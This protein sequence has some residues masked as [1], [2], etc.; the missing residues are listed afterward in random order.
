MRFSAIV[1]LSAL[2]LAFPASMVSAG[3]LPAGHP[4]IDALKDKLVATHAGV[5]T[6]AISATSYTYLHVKGDGGEEW[7]ATSQMD[8]KPKSKIRWN[9]GSIMTNFTSKSLNRTFDKIRFVEVV[10]VQK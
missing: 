10:E 1:L 9:D 7:L 2:V 6:E 4:N 3:D 5:V 8:I